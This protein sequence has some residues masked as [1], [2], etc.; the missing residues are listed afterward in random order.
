MAQVNTRVRGMRDRLEQG[1]I[2]RI[3]RCF[4]TG[5]ADNRLPNTA[6]VAFE[7]I[8][9][10]GILLL[11]NKEG[12]AASSG[13][14]CTSGSLQPSHVLRAMNIPYTAAHGAIRFSLSRDNTDDEVD[15]VLA[16]M[17]DVVDKLRDISPFWS[18][19]RA[20]QASDPAYA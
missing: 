10:E 15:R 16:V 1:L 17:P 2:E 14:A 18:K 20:P 8:E 19:E 12:I 3:G 9:G 7:Y 6:N 5:D 4:V 11:L 13:S